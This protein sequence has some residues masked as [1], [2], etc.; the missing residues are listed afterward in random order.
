MEDY[1]KRTTAMLV[2]LKLAMKLPHLLNVVV[3]NIDQLLLQLLNP[4]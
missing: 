1:R 3:A 4:Q 2:V